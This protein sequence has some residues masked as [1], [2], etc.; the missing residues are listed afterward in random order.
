[1]LEKRES[2]L[3]L[4]I[5][6]HVDRCPLSDDEI[7]VICGFKNGNLIRAF[8]EGEIRPPLELIDP[9]SDVFGCDYGEFLTL[10]IREW[11]SPAVFEWLQE[12]RFNYTD[13]VEKSWILALREIFGGT[14]P[15]L[16]DRIRA[17]LKLV[18]KTI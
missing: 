15:E 11:F 3:S 12:V 2:P 5:K 1:M 16:S 6:E 13:P 10:A 17:R 18:M 9:L 14:V 7:G 8:A 4:Y